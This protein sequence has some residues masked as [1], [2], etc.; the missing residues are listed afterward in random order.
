MNTLDV[1]GDALRDPK[2]FYD[3]R[4]RRGYMRDFSALYETCR[5][6]AIRELFTWLKADGLAPQTIL[7]Y[8]CGEGRYIDILGQAF[9][10]AA[11]HGCDISEQA[12]EIARNEHPQA[13]YTAMADER[14]DLPDGFCEMVICVEVLEHVRDARRT[15]QEIARVLA[16][17]GIAVVSTPCANKL[18]FE[19]LYNRLAG[20]LQ[21]SFDRYG[22]FAT[23]EPGHLRRLTDRHVRALFADAG[24]RSEK[25][26]HRGHVFSTVA[27]WLRPAWLLSDRWRLRL[28]LLDWR[29]FKH[30]PNGASMLAVGRKLARRPSTMMPAPAALPASPASSS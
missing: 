20:G 9:P 24:I 14:V 21:P 12:L 30:L 23:D 16:P 28:A 17:G 22:R 2:A 1:S 18:S 7:D 26:Y 15:V 8:G 3:A 11:L 4:Y 5:L 29:F 25:I 6:A 10:Q 27:D 19:W 13:S